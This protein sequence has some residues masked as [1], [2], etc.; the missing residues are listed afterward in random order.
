MA[1]APLTMLFNQL[2]IDDIAVVSK[3]YP[4]YFND[5]KLVGITAKNI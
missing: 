1:F 5:L 3:S 4:N 2:N